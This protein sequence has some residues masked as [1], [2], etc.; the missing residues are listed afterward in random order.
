MTLASGYGRYMTVGEWPLQFCNGF[1]TA[2]SILKPTC[3]GFRNETA[4][5]TQKRNRH[6]D[7][8][9]KPPPGPVRATSARVKFTTAETAI[10]NGRKRV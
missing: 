7:P 5:W 4:T 8:E 1:V 10:A 2:V 3:G 6:L 9:T